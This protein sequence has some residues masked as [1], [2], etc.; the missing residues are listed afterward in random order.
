MKKNIDLTNKKF[1]NWT[2]LHKSEIIKSGMSYWLCI[3]ECGKEKIVRTTHLT[4]GASKSCG[5]A[6]IDNKLGKNIG[7]WTV[8]ERDNNKP[9]GKGTW[10]IC[11]C[12]CGKEKS[13][14]SGNL[15]SGK[16]KSCGTCW[17]R[18]DTDDIAIHSLFQ[19]YKYTAKKRNIDFSLKKEEFKQ[20][21]KSNCFYCNKEPL[22]ISNVKSYKDSKECERI[23][24]YNG[25]D[26]K[27]NLIGYELKNCVPCCKI[28]NTSKSILSIKEWLE[29]I[30]QVLKWHKH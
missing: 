3:C 20:L 5:C 24:K 16:S 9:I 7:K 22:Q 19:R 15:S 2:V 6:Q 21:I 14:S 10:W 17:Q 1:R 29:H 18:K 30:T 28:C 12:E 13:L 11:R 26:R 27:D 4:S 8:I 23:F 25:I